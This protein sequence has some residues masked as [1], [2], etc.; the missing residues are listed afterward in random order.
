MS[1]TDIILAA[2][3]KGMLH[4]FTFHNNDDVLASV[5][6]GGMLH[7][8]RESNQALF[9][10]QRPGFLFFWGVMRT[11]PTTARH[12]KFCCTC[13]VSVGSPLWCTAAKRNPAWLDSTNH[14]LGFK[15]WETWRAKYECQEAS[16]GTTEWE[17]WYKLG[18]WT[19]WEFSD[20]GGKV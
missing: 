15:T 8:A 9:W 19:C 4:K 7:P 17:G 18:I 13:Y 14:R 10:A 2:A 5:L 11:L 12:S 20:K 1:V 16:N 3:G 6:E